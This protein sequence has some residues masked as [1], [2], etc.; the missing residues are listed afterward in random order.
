MRPRAR[1]ARLPFLGETLSHTQIHTRTHHRPRLASSGRPGPSTRPKPAQY[2]TRTRAELHHS[3]GQGMPRMPRKHAKRN[4]R[5]S[6]GLRSS[7]RAIRAHE[8]SHKG[9]KIRES[10]AGNGG[11]TP[12]CQNSRASE[13]SVVRWCMSRGCRRLDSAQFPLLLCFCTPFTALPFFFVGIAFR[14]EDAIR[15]A[16]AYAPRG[17]MWTGVGGLG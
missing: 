2:V 7:L 10:V 6:L 3:V 16:V 9:P 15:G 11:V 8:R 5:T 14:T 1:K 4:P 12:F 17:V 13:I